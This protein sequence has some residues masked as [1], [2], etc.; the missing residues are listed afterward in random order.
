MSPYPW[1]QTGL[2]SGSKNSRD[3]IFRWQQP[4]TGTIHLER[5]DDNILVRGQLRGELN[6][7]C[8]RCLDDFTA[9]LAADFDL[10]LKIGRPPVPSQE[11]ELDS[12][13]LDEDLFSG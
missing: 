5:H 11:V 1:M 7:T 13:E 8:S 2:P 10:L 6:F 12:E 9:P 4:I 3:W